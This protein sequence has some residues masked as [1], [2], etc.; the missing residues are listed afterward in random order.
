[1]GGGLARHR[2]ATRPSRSRQIVGLDDQLA[3]MIA[4]RDEDE[5]GA[6]RAHGIESFLS[7]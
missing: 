7:G 6:T 5:I 3:E 1:L 4:M 2:V